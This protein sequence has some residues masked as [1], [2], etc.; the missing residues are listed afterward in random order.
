M[1]ATIPPRTP[2]TTAAMPQNAPLSLYLNR[3]STDSEPGPVNA[4]VKAATARTRVYSYPP[5]VMKKLPKAWQPWFT[6]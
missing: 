6:A 2:T 4:S 1:S 5:V 3:A